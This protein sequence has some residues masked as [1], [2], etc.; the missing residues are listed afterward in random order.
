M[1]T[2]G[3]YATYLQHK[4]SY[5]RGENNYQYY[6]FFVG[7]GIPII[8]I[9]YWAPTCV[10]SGVL[11]FQRTLVPLGTGAYYTLQVNLGPYALLK[12]VRFY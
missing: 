6:F 3:T 2:K 9:V 12:G 8:S 10:V 11:L 1:R 4:P 7:G 5:S